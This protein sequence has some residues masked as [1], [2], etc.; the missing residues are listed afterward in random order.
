MHIYVKFASYFKE[1]VKPRVLVQDSFVV[2]DDRD[3][4]QNGT[5]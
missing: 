1:F 5:C 3:S 4:V 2:T